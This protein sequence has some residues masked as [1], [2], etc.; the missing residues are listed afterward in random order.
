MLN[1]KMLWK[2]PLVKGKKNQKDFYLLCK[3]G[4]SGTAKKRAPVNI[5]FLIDRS[6][7]MSS[8]IS[9]ENQ[10]ESM[11]RL[12]TNSLNNHGYMPN[13]G[14]AI[15]NNLISDLNNPLNNNLNNAKAKLEAMNKEKPSSTFVM[16][17]TKLDLVKRATLKAIEQL[18]ENDIVSILVFDDKVDTLCS[19]V[20]AKDK[21]KLIKLVN[22]IQTRGMT[23][24][25]SAW[26]AGAYAVS[27]NMK[28]G[29]L[30]RV[31]LLTDGQ[32]NAGEKRIDVI[33]SKVTELADADVSTSTFGVGADYNEDLL[34]KIAESGEGNYYYIKNDADFEE[35]FAEEFN[36]M[37]NIAA[38]K[39]LIKI[40][41][42]MGF[43]VLNDLP[44]TTPETYKV[45]NILYTREKEI[46]FKLTPGKIKDHKIKFTVSYL[47]DGELFTSEF[48]TEIPVSEKEGYFEEQEVIDK[49]AELSIA[50]E[51]EKAMKALDMGNIDLARSTLNGAMAMA[52][53]SSASV[54]SNSLQ[55]LTSLTENLDNGDYNT[56]RKTALYETYNRRTGKEK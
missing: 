3:M 46:L 25:F 13:F 28:E 56:L 17:L 12:F 45:G 53:G 31:L 37:N 14:G 22:G 21:E 7:S 16:P 19:G 52:A 39:S 55:S 40:D 20:S 44:Q 10:N 36:D 2:N 43:E 41:T 35:L 24:I 38:K 8:P 27:N 5:S 54:S 9:P 6:G 26:W 32:T 34:Q 49:I 18:D 47:K 23:D 29:Y 4:I 30:N 15:P 1:L 50:K 51:K 48:S 11:N 42:K 33:A